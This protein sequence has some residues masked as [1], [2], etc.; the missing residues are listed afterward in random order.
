ML[1]MDNFIIDWSEKSGCTVVC[2]MIFKEMGIL[3][4]ALEFHSW[5]HQFRNQV[6]YDRYGRVSMDMLR[7]NEHVKMKFVRNPYTRAVSSYMAAE[8]F[9]R[10]GYKEVGDIS[11]LEFLNQVKNEELVDAHWRV[12]RKL[13]EDEIELD[14]IIQIENIHEEAK[15]LSK[16]YGLNFETEFTSNH[17]LTKNKAIDTF[18]GRKKYSEFYNKKFEIPDYKCFYDDEIKALVDDIYA[19]DIYGYNYSF[20]L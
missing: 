12:Q 9:R 4:E 16:K 5:I 19:D 6:F 10:T 1:L 13:Y 17:H 14:E 7:L 20:D 15:R 3:D 8:F 2:K 11:F 18:V